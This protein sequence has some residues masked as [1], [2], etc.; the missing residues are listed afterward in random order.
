MQRLALMAILAAVLTSGNGAASV[1]GPFDALLAREY[2][3]ASLAFERDRGTPED[4]Q[5]VYDA[6]RDLEVALPAGTTTDCVPLLAALRRF[7]SGAV[8]AAEALDRLAPARRPTAVARA[9][10][11][12][13][14]VELNRR[15]CRGTGPAA[16]AAPP[17]LDTPRSGE[18]FDGRVLFVRPARAARATLHVDGTLVGS[19]VLPGV[20]RVP[21]SARPIG[22]VEVRFGDRSGKVVGR[23][24]SR[25]VWL[26][27]SP[28]WGVAESARSD[29]ALASR[30]ARLGDSFDGYSAFWVA[31]LASGA[32]AGWN[33]AALFPAASTVKLGVLG[34]ALAAFDADD[35]HDARHELDAITAWSSN[36][37]ANRLSRLVGL[38][39]VT[40]SLRSLGATASTYT[41]DYRVATALGGRSSQPPLVSR[42]VT[43]AA[44]LGRVL[45]SLHRIAAGDGAL[46]RRTGL[47]KHDARLVIG[48]LLRAETIGENA[49]L[50]APFLP[51]TLA[52]AHKN[53][54]ISN[55]R[56]TAALV[57]GPSGPVV[58]TVLTYRNRLSLARARALG[59]MVAAIAEERA[60][61]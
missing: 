60:L 36:L 42:R 35:V 8:T 22:R 4:A 47:T 5:R 53:G 34:A 57:Y 21:G 37:A 29:R 3:A 2:A 56:H 40:R 61:R 43:T 46:T 23:A 55:A 44:D 52:V 31:D 28:A 32:S 54:W 14:L 26:L 38:T 9:R 20:L 1:S 45:V 16:P 39:A 25:R 59:R 19:T 7:A 15:P 30:L 51:R 17:E 58:V 24:V 6:A 11:A 41:G 50:V 48:G 13:A 18:T 49:G 27:P 33:A 12:R 10:A